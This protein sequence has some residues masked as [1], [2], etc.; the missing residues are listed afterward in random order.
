VVDNRLWIDGAVN[1]AYNV[2]K[3][4]V[5][6]CGVDAIDVLVLYVLAV[7]AFY[8]HAVEGSV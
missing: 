5:I 3:L 7:G 2:S 1:P 4:P 8:G 6:H